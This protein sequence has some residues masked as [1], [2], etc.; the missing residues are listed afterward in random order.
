MT[1]PKDFLYENSEYGMLHDLERDLNINSSY[2]RFENLTTSD[3]ENAA[4][5][6]V[7]IF[8]CPPS[9]VEDW[10]K[11]WV[12]FNTVLFLKKSPAQIILTLNRLMKRSMKQRNGIMRFE[13][14]LMKAVN[15]FSLQ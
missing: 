8:M 3:F 11:S 6:F 12:N 9:E 1:C 2:E 10:F 13:E 7:Y 15:T 4:E 5:M 14:L